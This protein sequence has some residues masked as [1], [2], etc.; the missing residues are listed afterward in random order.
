MSLEHHANHDPNLRLPPALLHFFPVFLALFTLTLSVAQH[1]VFRGFREDEPN[2]WMSTALMLAVLLLLLGA[3][4]NTALPAV[5]RWAAGVLSLVTGFAILDERNGYHEEWGRD[6]QDHWEIFTP[7]VRHYADDIIIILFAIAGGVLFY[8]FI[9]RLQNKRAYVP[10]ASVVVIVALAHGVLDVLG[11]GGRIWRWLDP[12][13]TKPQVELLTET[14]GVYEESC[15]VWTEWFV[16]LF[17]LKLLYDQR[18]PLAWSI[19]VMVGSFL[20]GIG[21]WAIEDPALGVPYMI[22]G[23]VLRFIRNYHLLFTL[24]VL[25]FAWASVVWWRFRGSARKQALAGLLFVAPWYAAL[26]DIAAGFDSFGALFGG[27]SLSDLPGQP[28]LLATIGGLLFPLAL[29][30]NVRGASGARRWKLLLALLLAAALVQ[31]ALWLMLAFMAALAL[32]IERSEPAAPSG[33]SRATWS[34]LLAGQAAVIAAIFVVSASGILPEYRFKRPEK[35]L[36]ETGWQQL[37]PGF[38]DDVPPEHEDQ[39]QDHDP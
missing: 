14:L 33:R 15:K 3:V 9:S 6:I 13:I 27:L 17:V 28:L 19:Q 34:A 30:L 22:M 23:R 12:D 20:A 35:V 25:F 38:Y 31:S 10:T 1:S 29:A 21:L 37:R 2:T 16:V 32:A 39:E 18:V 4:R 24:W 11:H 7:D 8:L 26:P 36:F 5:K